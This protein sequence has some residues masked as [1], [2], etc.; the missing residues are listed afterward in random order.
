[1]T[2][3]WHGD[4]P[5]GHV[6][7]HEGQWTRSS[8]DHVDADYLLAIKDEQQRQIKPTVSASVVICTRDRPDE[9]AA[10]PGLSIM[11]TDDGGL[12]VRVDVV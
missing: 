8:I 2:V 12:G 3:F 11:Q 7:V 10:W 9:L 6:L 4:R 1:M 5:I